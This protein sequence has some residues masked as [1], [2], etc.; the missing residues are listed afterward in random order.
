MKLFDIPSGYKS[1]ADNQLLTAAQLNLL[2]HYLDSQDRLSRLALTGAGIVCGFDVSY[3]NQVLTISQGSALTTDGDLIKLHSK[4]ANKITT[5]LTIPK[6]DFV[7]YA[8]F[9]NHKVEYPRFLDEKKSYIPIFELLTASEIKASSGAKKLTEINITDMVVVLYL[10]NYSKPYDVCNTTDCDSQGIPETFNLK[11]FMIHAKDVE[12][13]LLPKDAIFQQFKAIKGLPQPDFQINRILAKELISNDGKIDLNKYNQVCLSTATKFNKLC[14]DLFGTLHTALG[15]QIPEIL[16][17]KNVYTPKVFPNSQYNYNFLTDLISTYNEILNL[18]LKLDSICNHPIDAFPKHLLLG[19]H[20]D[21]TYRHK[22]YK[23]KAISSDHDIRSKITS[24]L[25]RFEAKINNYQQSNT[26]AIELRP[27]IQRADLSDKA[28]PRYYTSNEA[29]RS[30]WKFGLS[31]LDQQSINNESRFRQQLSH[32]DFVRIEGSYSKNWANAL[33]T[34]NQKRIEYGLNFDVICLNA[35]LVI[36]DINLDQY[37]IHFQDLHAQYSAWKAQQS[38]L[39]QTVSAFLTGF[40][41]KP[42]GGHGHIK[43]FFEREIVGIELPA[44]YASSRYANVMIEDERYASKSSSI[45]SILKLGSSSTSPITE[46]KKTSSDIQYETEA[47]K[48]SKINPSYYSLI[49]YD[50]AEDIGKGFESIQYVNTNLSYHDYVAV[51][52]SDIKK[53]IPNLNEWLQIDKDIRVTYPTRLMAAINVYINRIPKDINAVNENSLRL[54]ESALENLCTLTN[55]A[56]SLITETINDPQNDY[57]RK[58]FEEHYTAIL[59]RLKENCCAA[60]FL[61][62]ILLEINERK[63]MILHATKFENFVAQHPGLEHM[64][65]VPEA[66]TFVLLY[67]SKDNSVIADFALPYRCCSKQPAI[68]FMVTPPVEKVKEVK[69]NIDSVICKSADET[70]SVPFELDPSDAD[71]QLVNPLPGISIEKHAI[72]VDKNFKS[73]E[74]P[75]QFMTDKKLLEK[76]LTVLQKGNL[77]L[78]YEYN[79]QK[80]I[81]VV[82]SNINTNKYQWSINGKEVKSTRSDELIIEEKLKE[83]ITILL[84]VVTACEKASAK[85]SISPKDND[86]TVVFTIPNQVCKHPKQQVAVAF[87]TVPQNTKVTLESNYAGLSIKDSSLIIS[88]A[89]TAFNSPISFMINGKLIDQTI[90]VLARE[91]VELVYQFDEKLNSY[92]ISSNVSVNNFTWYLNSQKLDAESSDRLILKSVPSGKN[93]VLLSIQTPCGVETA[94][95]DFE[96][97]EKNEFECSSTA[98]ER[99]NDYK[100]Q[101]VKYVNQKEIGETLMNDLTYLQQV[102]LLYEKAPENF[103]N[104]REIGNLD[105]ARYTFESLNSRIFQEEYSKYREDLLEVYILSMLMVYAMLLCLDERFSKEYQWAFTMVLNTIEWHTEHS[106]YRKKI[107]TLSPFVK[108]LIETRLKMGVDKSEDPIVMHLSKLSNS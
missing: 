49:V 41:T 74:I 7:G 25:H 22:F 8:P 12:N 105:M 47:T 42:D 18:T 20:K 71:I 73:F 106:L 93:E 5:A 58:N 35:D 9:N 91:V 108:E 19:N 6:I 68:S 92:F 82:K 38:C 78:S 56:F 29:L 33:A 21:T 15:F 36:D 79:E 90:K 57:I 70:I 52:E 2:I 26:L 104:G 64:A 17:S 84:E 99:L 51:F 76:T 34:I 4:V 89:F 11:Y 107:E 53:V 102:V 14:L 31:D 81:H 24:L 28:I 66:G 77:S 75:I 32:L 80:E 39:L 94:V 83:E 50:G 85:L 59:N 46:E 60:D 23:S 88:A 95:L 101:M 13:Y 40:S 67:Q 98:Q 96:H 1:F 69:F 62:V 63:K 30:F 54:F 48:Y 65:G 72:K 10:E 27:S 16:R 100:K 61:K 86:Q 55:D 44:S 103:L 45:A 3:D 43:D 97:L 37:P 87:A